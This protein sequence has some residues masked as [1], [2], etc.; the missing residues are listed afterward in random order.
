MTS[1]GERGD[2]HL[3]DE[4]RQE[5]HCDNQ[6]ERAFADSVLVTKLVEHGEHHAVPRCEQPR[7]RAENDDDRASTHSASITD[8]PADRR[9]D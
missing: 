9:M 2:R 3:G 7:Q 4:R 1:I 6:P 8:G 5:T